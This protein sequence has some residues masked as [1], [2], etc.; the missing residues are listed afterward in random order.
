[1]GNGEDELQ[2]ESRAYREFDGDEIDLVGYF[3]VIFKYRRVILCVC[4]IAMA[5]TGAACLLSPKV[6]S[7]TA[8]LV[9]PMMNLQQ[10]SRFEE[11]SGSK[12][13]MIAD[14][15][16]VPNL[17]RF[18]TGL[19]RSR[20]IEDAVID[21][22]NLLR[23]YGTDKRFVAR[24]NLR[25][26][27]TVKTQDNIIRITV[28]D[29]DPNRAAAIANAYVDELDGQNKRLSAGMAKNQRIFL[30]NRLTEVEQKLSKFDDILSREARIQ[31]ILFE[32]LMREYELVK[33]EEA[34]NMPTVQILDKAI[35]PEVKVPRGT[36]KKT[37]LAGFISLV[38]A[39]F[40]A[41]AREYFKRMK[42]AWAERERGLHLGSAAESTEG[43]HLGELERRRRIVA[44]GRR[45]HSQERKAYSRGVSIR[46]CL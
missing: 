1:M 8:T 28:T 6:Y 29:R 35:V 13:D 31:E 10:R 46:R 20:T 24:I 22:L 21:R 40:A 2:S 37:A 32:M 26:N 43:A 4:A 19:L 34:K 17:A 25:E 36:I 44:T 27:T 23:V 18:Y 5:V 38:F 39:S 11:N 9:P 42:V 41:V 7:A 12:G 14:I 30:E 45:R 15:M 3:R 16:G 33:I